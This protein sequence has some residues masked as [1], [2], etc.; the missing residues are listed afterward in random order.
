[1]SQD[2]KLTLSV[3]ALHKIVAYK[4]YELATTFKAEKVVDYLIFHLLIGCH[5]FFFVG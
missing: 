4:K 1:M 3:L 2:L 5:D